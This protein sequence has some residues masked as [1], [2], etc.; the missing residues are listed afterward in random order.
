MSSN[1]PLSS[2]SQMRQEEMTPLP[3]DAVG[4]VVGKVK[5]MPVPVEVRKYFIHQVVIV[6]LRAEACV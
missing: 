1:G 6:E 5:E 4:F 2:Q 3:L